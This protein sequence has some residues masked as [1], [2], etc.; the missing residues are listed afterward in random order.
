MKKLVHKTIVLAV[1][2][3]MSIQMV[4][5]QKADTSLLSPT[6]RTMYD[7]YWKRHKTLNTVGW[8]LVV[9]GAA[10]FITGVAE[11]SNNSFL[12]SDYSPT[13]GEALF[14]VGGAMVL[15]SIPCFILSGTNARRAYLEL[16]SGNVPGVQGA[17]Y[18]GIGIKIKL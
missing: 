10:M 17:N 5:A 8:V 11:A 1:V 3:L 4:S 6:K 14:F 12:S 7:L 15:A 18:A 2:A 13:K 9:P 16:K